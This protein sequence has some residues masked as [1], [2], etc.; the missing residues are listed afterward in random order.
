MIIVLLLLFLFCFLL[1]H[2]TGLRKVLIVWDT[3]TLKLL[4]RLVWWQEAKPRIFGSLIIYLFVV[5]FIFCFVSVS[6]CC[7]LSVAGLCMSEYLP[8]QRGVLCF[9]VNWFVCLF[10]CSFI[11]FRLLVCYDYCFVFICCF[12]FACYDTDLA[13]QSLNCLRHSDVETFEAF[14]L[15]ARSKTEDFWFVYYLFVWLR[16]LSIVYFLFCFSLLC[17][18]FRRFV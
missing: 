1:R 7:V 11:Y 2:D 10:N 18:V 3:A 13:T 17:F 12:C 6:H 8:W 9:L 15:V 5:S 4:K 14:S 16:I